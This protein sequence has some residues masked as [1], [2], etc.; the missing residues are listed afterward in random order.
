[1]TSRLLENWYSGFAKIGFTAKNV[2]FGV[3]ENPLVHHGL[4]SFEY[5]PTAPEFVAP[6]HGF[7]LGESIRADGDFRDKPSP[8]EFMDLVTDEPTETIRKTAADDYTDYDSLSFEFTF[9]SGKV[10]YPVSVYANSDN[11]FDP[12]E[13]TGFAPTYVGNAVIE[14]SSTPTSI[15]DGFQHPL[16]DGTLTEAIDGDGYYVPIGANFNNLNPDIGSG[17]YHLGEDWNGEGGGNTDLGDPVFA[18]SNGQVTQSDWLDSLGYYVVIRHDLSSPITLN[19]ITTSEIFSL[20]AHLNG[21]SYLSVGDIVSMGQPIGAVGNSGDAGPFAHLHFEIRL[22]T[23]SGFQDTD[24]YNPNGAPPGWV[25]PTDFIESHRTINATPTAQ[26]NNATLAP[27]ESIALADLFDWSDPDGLDDIVA[28]H[29]RDR[30]IGGGY[31]TFNGKHMPDGE[32]LQNIPIDQIH[33]WAF[34]AGSS[35]SVDDIGFNAVDASG[36]YNLPSAVATVTTS[37]AAGPTVSIGDAAGHEGEAVIFE[38]TLSQ[39]SASD[40]IVT[41]GITN[42]TTDGSD[43]LTSSTTITFSAGETSAPFLVYFQPDGVV[44]PDQTFTVNIVSANGANIGDGS[45]VGTIIGSDSVPADAS[46]SIAPGSISVDENVGTVTFTITRG[47]AGQAQV[48]YVSTTVD[49]GDPNELDYAWIKNLAVRFAV[50]ETEKT[51]TVQILNDDIPELNQTF[52]IIV[53]DDPSKDA[54]DFL[55]SAEF[56]IIDDDQAGANWT[57]TP[58]A[59]SVDETAGTITFTIT[60]SDDTDAQTVYFSTYQDQNAYNVGDYFGFIAKPVTFAAGQASTTV[61]VVIK[62][63]PYQETSETFSVIL[64]QSTDVADATVLASA[65]FTINDDDT[66]APPTSNLQTT[67]G[68]LDSGAYGSE[69]H[70]LAEL[71]AAAYNL[72]AGEQIVDGLNEWDNSGTAYASYV[73]ASRNLHLLTST[74]LPSLAK[75]PDPYSGFDFDGLVDGIYIHENA[76][77][78]V[79]RSGDA[80]FL[81]FRGT[82]DGGINPFGGL[83]TTPDSNDWENLQRHYNLYTDLFTALFGEGGY[84]E[85]VNSDGDSSNDIHQVF[86]TGHSLGGAMAEMFMADKEHQDTSALSFDSVTFASIG[87]EGQLDPAEF[88]TGFDNR[89]AN[90]S[91]DGDI[92]AAWAS[93]YGHT[94]Y[95]YA[96]AHLG[97]APSISIPIV[98]AALHSMPLY[99]EVAQLIGGTSGLQYFSVEDFINGPG[100]YFLDVF[101]SPDTDRL[102]ARWPSGLVEGSALDDFLHGGNGDDQIY[103]YDGDDTLYALDGSDWL[104]GGDGFDQ[105]IAGSGAGD[106]VYIGGNDTDTISYESTQAGVTVNLGT[107]YA[108]GPEIGNDRVFDVENVLG[109]AGNDTLV[110][111]N[112]ANEIY[113]LLGDDTLSGGGGDDTLYGGAGND[114]AQFTGNFINYAVTQIDGDTVQLSDGTDGRDGIDTVHEV[115]FFQFADQTVSLAEVVLG[116]PS[117]SVMLGSLAAADGAVFVGD[118]DFDNLGSSAASV[119]DINGD[120]ID[121]FI[122]AANGHDA[123]GPGAGQSYVIFGS[124]SGFGTLSGGRDVLDLTSFS[125]SDGFIV[126]GDTDAEISGAAVAPLGDI[127]G[128]G[129]DD[130]AV[131]A[132]RGGDGVWDDG[133]FETGEAYIIFGST[134][135][136]G[137]LDNGQLIVD[138]ANLSA[139]QGFIVQGANNS[140]HA[141]WAI[142]GLGDINGD[143]IGDFVVGAH[144]ADSSTESDVGRAYVIFGSDS[145]LGVDVDGRQVVYLSDLAPS[146]GFIIQ[147]EARNDSFAYADGVTSAGDI[148]GDGINDILVSAPGNDGAGLSTGAAYV[149]FG[150]SNRYGTLVDGQQLV[151][152]SLLSPEDGFVIQGAE[153]G[154]SIGISVSGIGDFNGDGYDDIIVG[155]ANSTA[156]GEGTGGAY[157]LFGSGE[158]FGTLV[159][160]RQ[161]VNLANLSPEDGFFLQGS[162]VRGYAGASVSAAGDF[163]GDGFDD[164]IVGVAS[165]TFSNPLVGGAYL[166]YGAAV[167]PGVI[168]DGHHVFDL[169]NLSPETG[170][171]FEGEQYDSRTGRN[172]STAGDVNDDGYDD[173][174][175]G[176]AG[177]NLGG[178]SSGQSYLVYGGPSETAT[179]QTI[180]GD[181][182]AEQLAGSS[183]DDQISGGGGAD[184]I[185]TGAGDDVVQVPDNDF[186]RIDLGSGNDMLQLV[187]AGVI[188]DLTALD[189]NAL[190]D[191]EVID[192]TGSGANTIKLSKLDITSLAGDL[193]SGNAVL[194]ILGSPGDNVVIA[195]FADWTLQG[196]I[197]EGATTYTA[198]SNGNVRLL[199]QQGVIMG[200]IP[201][202]TSV[203]AISILENSIGVVYDAD[204]LDLDGDVLTYSIVVGQDSALFSIDPETGW[205]S[206][207]AAPDFDSPDDEDGDNTYEIEIAASDGAL[208]GS[209]A[210]AISV[211][212]VNDIAPQF[213]SVG[214]VSMEENDTG[215][216]YIAVAF[217]IEGASVSYAISGGADAGLFNIDTVTGEVT[218]KA[219]P[220]FEAPLDQGQNNQ[221]SIDVIVTD[222][223]G[224]TDTKAITINVTPQNEFAPT[225]DSLSIADFAEAETGVVYTAEVTDLDAGDSRTFSLGGADKDLFTINAAGEV[226]FK[227]APDFETP[228]DAGGNNIYNIDVTVIDSGGLSATKAVTITV[229]DISEYNVVP[230]TSGDDDLLGTIDA[231]QINAGAG[232]D[233]LTGGPGTDELNGGDGDDVFLVGAGDGPDIF[234]GGA[235][236]DTIA[237]VESGV[238]ISFAGGFGPANSI[239]VITNDDPGAGG[240]MTTITGTAAGETLDY[241][242]ETTPYYLDGLGGA[243][244]LRG[245]SADDVLAGGAGN[246]RLTGNG[247]ADT[248]VFTDGTNT[249]RITDFDPSSGDVINLAGVTGLNSFAD[250][251]AVMVSVF[252]GTRIDLPDGGRIFLVNVAPSALSADDFDFGAVPSPSS[253][254]ISRAV[255]VSG[256]TIEG[257]AGADA[258]DF[259]ATTLVGI[260]AIN[261]GEGADTVVGSSAADT[262]NGDGGDDTITGGGGNDTITGGT[263]NDTAIFSGNLADYT[264]TQIDGDSVTLVGPD[265]TDTV[266]EVEVFQFD[267]Q[268][269][270]FDALLGLQPVPIFT[271][272]ASANFAE[273]GVG[274][275]YD[276]D[277]TDAD[278][279]APTYAITGGADAALFDIDG[280]TGE[281]TFKAS[282]DYEAPGDAGGD[283]VYDIEVTATSDGDGTVQTVAITVTNE[284]DVAP[285]FSSGSAVN[286]AEG[287]TGTVYDANATDGDG[288]SPTYSISGGADAGLFDID[289]VT[290]EVTFKAAPDYEA[291]GDAGG[292]NIYNIEITASD[293]TLTD[294]QAVAITVTDVDDSGGGITTITGTSAGETLDASAESTPY[295][296][297]GLGGAD[298][299]KGG[300]A[301][302]VLAGGAGNDRM[303]GNGGADTFVFTDGTGRDRITDFDPSSG[304]VINLAGVTGWSSFADVQGAMTERFGRVTITL[305]DGGRIILVGIVSSDLN[306]NDFDFGA[307]PSPNAAM[308]SQNVLGST[309]ETDLSFRPDL[310]DWIAT[311]LELGGLANHRFELELPESFDAAS[312]DQAQQQYHDGSEGRDNSFESLTGEAQLS[313][314]RPFEIYTDW[315]AENLPITGEGIPM[316]DW[317]SDDFILSS[318]IGRAFD[319]PLAQR[320]ETILERHELR[321][322]SDGFEGFDKAAAVAADDSPLVREKPF[323]VSDQWSIDDLPTLREQLSS[324]VWSLDGFVAWE[325]FDIDTASFEMPIIGPLLANFEMPHAQFGFA[326]FGDILGSTV[327]AF[328]PAAEY[329]FEGFDR[330]ERLVDLQNAG[331]DFSIEAWSNDDFIFG[332]RIQAPSEG[333]IKTHAPSDEMP[334]I[335]HDMEPLAD[336]WAWSLGDDEGF[337]RG[338]RPV[339]LQNTEGDFSIETWSNDN[340]IFGDR[341]NAPSNDFIKTHN[342]S[343]EM[344]QIQHDMEPL[345][346]G[347]AWSLGD[348]GDVSIPERAIEA[349]EAWSLD[350]LQV[351]LD[352]LDQFHGLDIDSYLL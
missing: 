314:E 214:A 280:V 150:D 167:T 104:E 256:T 92:A 326:G 189:Q 58:T 325:G 270:S 310:G 195:D 41:L 61:T 265:G 251:Q 274:V 311:E 26:G 293:G 254:S 53:Q 295:Y 187:G 323:E 253:A 284:N 286:F 328:A 9:P 66:T 171:L 208:T 155:T 219:V 18:I 120:G 83:L 194:R 7:D 38:V 77:A 54:D 308:I 267:D 117:S 193:E 331:E 298:V 135:Q 180:F 320:F 334:Q 257:T 60:R 282:P 99:V 340:F 23:G 330:G 154:D 197:A 201:M 200:S 234:N 261:M 250:V 43:Y 289:S 67:K 103:G 68:L 122:V 207:I 283:N 338:E 52:G 170:Q 285:V 275:A 231:D 179:S 169:G 134:A 347:W 152:L 174:L 79:A 240:G 160:G 49:R 74:D 211:T 165:A 290:G 109:G 132:P 175:I 89:I 206:F 6:A 203:N 230:G 142:A 126:R 304:D 177:G 244:T 85:Q 343:D 36:D 299:L 72:V 249:D 51:V 276:A 88:E 237:A 281:V 56:T 2:A 29:V 252:R 305:P 317:N 166:I 108:S 213:I 225:I 209:Q 80:L 306:A 303:T 70:L 348:N 30:D 198:Y 292:N 33:L 337:D 156:G 278:S 19:G 5:E 90:I 333:F 215:P 272:G 107:T 151:D 245:G 190:R 10:L 319:H 296:L 133:T 218:F 339:D 233:R 50:G 172:V 96:I 143:G 63:D 94:G 11:K 183:V 302:D 118:T 173:I 309:T 349:R 247:G 24:G 168:A 4:L 130:L 59:L 255:A 332:D 182:T 184:V 40:V 124:T 46:W 147:G 42:G 93:F 164:V 84:I 288:T 91:I 352:G 324:F 185:R 268:T 102:H 21:A 199:I 98:G 65:T 232:N 327:E 113:G 119:G 350:D 73:A 322:T 69:L 13:T 227:S 125:S 127:N 315:E 235:G 105:F 148:N 273:N 162:V 121:D 137:T 25:D 62:D 242:G 341:F 316:F 128:D 163:N 188:L 57:I 116:A 131:G 3:F 336:G 158:G 111:S 101:Y 17:S 220:D 205:V 159:D 178:D 313:A 28:F 32:V 287:G 346:D 149:I 15:S 78:L 301:D 22:G 264:P 248:F 236:T 176:A 335:Q 75:T 141:G 1:M 300:S 31:L 112:A 271:S 47:N 136:I 226:N 35:N 55:T 217:D 110:G 12:D 161:I 192:L 157:V 145:G 321:Q 81:S 115:E 14:R 351:S 186:F 196:S 222:S 229:I 106:D 95:N 139:D 291:P 224:L 345:V 262:I 138:A 344:P 318:S 312:F 86:V 140:D 27:G 342:P 294:T 16:G 191:V 44:E 20:Y 266:H 123:G 39:P 64:Q 212:N 8:Y 297:D 307:P 34:V 243:D 202:I 221:Y 114:T 100:S 153:I 269:V 223:G 210:V 97:I 144:N 238:G 204:A 246:D 228:L 260:D 279:A 87:A 239:E 76:A 263:G 48:G 71:A 37:V 45:A 181:E 82:N 329:N 129:I 258:Y 146:E 216:A 259:S 277:A 241:S